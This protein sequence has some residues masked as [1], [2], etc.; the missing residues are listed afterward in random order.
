MNFIKELLLSEHFNKTLRWIFTLFFL[1][2][3]GATLT[4]SDVLNAIP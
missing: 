1:Y 2:L 4:V 3:T